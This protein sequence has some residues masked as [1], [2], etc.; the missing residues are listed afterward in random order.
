M[1]QG[2]FEFFFEFPLHTGPKQLKTG[3]GSKLLPTTLNPQKQWSAS[4]FLFDHFLEAR[5]RIEI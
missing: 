1:F 3:Q 2:I 5:A 4:R